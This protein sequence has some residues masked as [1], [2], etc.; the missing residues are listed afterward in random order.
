MI[1]LM[2]MTMISRGGQISI[3][4]EIRHRWGTSRVIIE[5]LGTGIMVR[6]IPADPIGAAIG[7]LA[8]DGPATDHI[9]AL[10]REAEDLADERRRGPR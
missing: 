7:S 6:P 3:P 4:A 8:G 9:R 1:H 5:D 2:K 10:E